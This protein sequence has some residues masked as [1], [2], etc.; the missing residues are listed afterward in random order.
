VFDCSQRTSHDQQACDGDDETLQRTA[1]QSLAESESESSGVRLSDVRLSVAVPAADSSVIEPVSDDTYHVAP[2]LTSTLGLQLD[3][4]TGHSHT[5]HGQPVSVPGRSVN[6]SCSTPTFTT[7]VESPSQLGLDER[8]VLT[9]GARKDDMQQFSTPTYA[10]MRHFA[11]SPLNT[12]SSPLTLHDRDPFMSP[13]LATDD[14][15]IH[16]CPVYFVVSMPML[17]SSS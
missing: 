13:L 17:S 5:G 7:P 16:I 11:Q 4:H 14:L 8:L 10:K 9:A 6:R 12:L 3:L 2:P 15:L 1:S